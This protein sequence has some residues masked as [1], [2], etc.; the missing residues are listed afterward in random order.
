MDLVSFESEEEWNLVKSFMGGAGIKEIWTS[1]RLCDAEVIF[2]S[3]IW[4]WHA[5]K[6]LC[7]YLCFFSPICVQ[8]SV[9]FFS[10]NM[11]ANI[12]VFLSLNMCA[13]ICGT[14]VSGCDADH[15]KPLNI[16]GWFWASTLVK[17]IVIPHLSRCR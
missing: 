10:P 2:I 11:C 8:I 12:C 5:Y 3:F 1:G 7:K 16:N 4:V 17:V 14:Q 6:Y 13:N 15:Y 9:F